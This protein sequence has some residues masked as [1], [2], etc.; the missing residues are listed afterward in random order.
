MRLTR[1]LQ[2]SDFDFL[3]QI[4]SKMNENGSVYEQGKSRTRDVIKFIER[5]NISYSQ[6]AEFIKYNFAE[7]NCIITNSKTN[8]TKKEKTDED[9]DKLLNSLEDKGNHIRAIFTVERLT[10]GWD[11][12]NLFDIVRLYQGQNAG[13]STRTTPEATTKEKQ[14]IG[15]GVRYYPFSYKDKLKNK[16]KFDEDLKN[17]LR[18]LEELYYYTYDEESRYISHLKEELRKDG[19]IRDN[20][21]IKTF[22]IKDEFKDND[23]YKKIKIWKNDQIDNPNRKKK[24]LDDIAT[25]FFSP[26][27]I[28]G[29]D[30]VEGH[31]GFEENDDKDRL[32]IR[33]K[34]S[35]T[36]DM[37]F[38]EFGNHII[39]KAI[40]IKAK[41]DKSLFQ[42]D[43]MKNELEIESMED[44]QKDAFL[45]DFNIPIVVNSN[46]EFGDVSNREKLKILLVFL[47]AFARE[48]KMIIN[49][50][51]GTDFTEAN[52]SEIFGVPKTKAIEK[53]EDSERI[54]NELEN[55]KWYVLDNFH[56]TDQEKELIEE[57]RSTIDNL[58]A[59]YK[60]VYLL[61]NEEVYKIYDFDK[62]TGFQ[63]DFILFLNAGKSQYYQVFM[64][65]KGEHLKEHDKW[66]NE[67][68]KK[69][70]EKYGQDDILTFES[71]KYR[72]IGLP[73]ERHAKK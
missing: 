22:K 20:K 4:E 17:E 70:T 21:V 29:L 61:R 45:G 64:E 56:G 52:F 11:V 16:R 41:A 6:I 23:F 1:D 42:F 67:F 24:V 51:K 9:Q 48:F 54:A 19:Y 68:L 57:I 44:L 18:V 10:E 53:D 39:Y 27:K 43:M 58:K 25:D 33:E 28:T 66:K 40:S 49:P 36:L 71:K 8:T 37:R 69:I 32:K 55:E 12:L 50:K 30:Y 35:K 26:Y 60:E 38:K 15:R 2:A 13:G 47:D 73:Y 72:L 62:G 63:P 34:G 14:L 3:N 5:E 31:F 46:Q 59:K 7:K 65:P